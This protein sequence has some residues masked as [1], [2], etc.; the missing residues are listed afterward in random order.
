[1]TIGERI[2]T[3]RLENHMTQER[4]ARQLKI[5]PQ[6]V[7]KWEKDIT[8]PDI[9]LLG[10]IAD[11]FRVTTDEL[12]GAGQYREQTCYPSYRERL[13][14]IYENS[15]E[16]IDFQKAVAAYQEVLL[17]GE[18]LQRDY[19]GYAWLHELHGRKELQI[20]RKYYEKVIAEAKQSGS[21]EGLK[22]GVQLSR[23]LCDFG[24]CEEAVA[25]QKQQ[26]KENPENLQI[27]LSLLWTLYYADRAEE[28]L[29]YI[30]QAEQMAPENP[31]VL[32]TI[33]ELLGG[34]NG[35]GR[36]EEAICYWDRALQVDEDFGD[37]RYGKAYAYE[38][39]GNTEEA[40]LEYQKICAWLRRRGAVAGEIRRV[41][42]KIRE[43]A[44]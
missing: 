12:L 35:F 10:E 33:G 6:T 2:R 14:E 37:A 21:E 42:D 32:T 15:R 38:Q 28:A 18:P 27:L 34:E 44:R 9:L 36:F 11:C 5:S 3:L 22:A 7:S 31:Y 1:M 4:L 43:L 19:F 13:M 26:Q 41:E 20:A 25:M 24:S 30:E 23:M 8:A 39:L 29:D 16:E 40:R 17:R